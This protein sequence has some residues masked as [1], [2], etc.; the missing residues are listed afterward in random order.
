MA[1]HVILEAG[2]F[3]HV[4][5]PFDVIIGDKLAYGDAEK[6]V[7]TMTGEIGE[8][9]FIAY[10]PEQIGRGFQVFWHEGEARRVVLRLPL[11]CCEPEMREFYQTVQRIA[12]FW[13]ARLIVDGKRTSLKAFMATLEENVRFNADTIR[14]VGKKIVSETGCTVEILGAMWPL[15]PGVEEGR[16]FML[17]PDSFAEWL[18][19][20]QAID[21]CYWPLVYAAPDNES[22]EGWVN[23]GPL[24]VPGIYR[25]HTPPS[26]FTTPHPVTGR[27][28]PVVAWRVMISD[29]DDPICQL[30]YE[31][32]RAKLPADKVHRYDR[33]MI[34]IE[35]MSSEELRAIYQTE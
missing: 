27:H 18:H 26:G 8:K 9:E 3:H 31:A 17:D 15:R 32:F 10:L 14:E 24:G 29:D 21:A 20:K 5:L 34:L 28:V 7:Q 11:P 16:M 1:I 33:D 4:P 6:Y 13:K 22:V 12:E 25:N 23:F 19:E 30:S 35:P 2:L